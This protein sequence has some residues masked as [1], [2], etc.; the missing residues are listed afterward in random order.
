M[1]AVWQAFQIQQTWYET[2][3]LRLVLRFAFNA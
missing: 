1:R 3:A 2:Q